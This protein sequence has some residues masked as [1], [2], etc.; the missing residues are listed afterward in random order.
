MHDTIIDYLINSFYNH[1]E[2]KLLMPELEKQLYDGT[3]TS[4]KAAISLIDKY[5]IK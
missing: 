4:Y 1:E 5:H 3:I 2:I